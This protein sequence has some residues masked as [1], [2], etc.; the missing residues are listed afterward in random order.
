MLNVSRG[1]VQHA[2]Q[3]QEK[4]APELKAAVEQGHIAVSVAAK[5]AALPAEDQRAIAEKVK[6]RNAKRALK[7]TGQQGYR[8]SRAGRAWRRL[9]A[10]RYSGT[11]RRK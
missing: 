8:G 11:P 2:A 9:P 6:A 1:S 10:G 7:I 5:A 4:A 3:V